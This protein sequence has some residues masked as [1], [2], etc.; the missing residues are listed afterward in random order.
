MKGK[1]QD[2]LN[3]LKKVT[4]IAKLHSGFKMS[5][6]LSNIYVSHNIGGVSGG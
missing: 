2:Y 5:I 1:E 6:H 4:S 3:Y